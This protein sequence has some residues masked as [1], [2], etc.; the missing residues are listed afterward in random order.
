MRILLTNDDG[1]HAA[2]LLALR[3]ALTRLGEVTVAA[4]AHERSAVSHALSL[5]HPLPEPRRIAAGAGGAVYAVDGTPVDCVKFALDRLCFRRPDLVVSG[6]NHGPNLGIDV[7]YSGTVAGAAEGAFAGLPAVAVSLAV[8]RAKARP[9]DFAA[10][11][12]WAARFLRESGARGWLRPARV[13]N[14]N[15]PL[16]PRGLRWTEMDRGLWTEA[17]V[18][19]RD[20]RGRAYYWLQGL[21]PPGAPPRMPRD[22]RT[23]T[24]QA[25]VAARFAS[26]TPLHFDLTDRRLLQAVATPA[27]A[28]PRRPR[29]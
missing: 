14:L 8:P 1:V 23:P 4:P 7:F 16:K 12:R 2:G 19:R 20:P 9:A 26:V 29:G 11:A 18:R 10:A 15:I 24:D 28:R 22:G 3:A 17:Y 25:V 6:I 13:L 27:P 5:H 21:P